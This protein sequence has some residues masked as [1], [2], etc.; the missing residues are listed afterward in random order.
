MYPK[1]AGFPS[2]TLQSYREPMAYFLLSAWVLVGLTSR[3]MVQA[4]AKNGFSWLQDQLVP[5]LRVVRA[6][7]NGYH[8]QQLGV[9]E[10]T[11]HRLGTRLLVGTQRL[12]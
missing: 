9:V 5:L 2:E 8:S 1:S 11:L 4:E 12:P 6:G 10:T 3:P 7:G